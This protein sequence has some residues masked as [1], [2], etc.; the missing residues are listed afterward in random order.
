MLKLH[1]LKLI[2]AFHL[3]RLFLWEDK[4]AVKPKIYREKE[5]SI[6]NRSIS[7][8]SLKVL[9]R[10]QQKGFEAYLVGGGVRDLLLDHQPK[11]FD[12]ATNAHPNEIKSIFNNCRIIGRRFRLAHILFGRD[13][14]EVAT[15]RADKEEESRHF[16]KSDTGFLMRDNIYGEIDDD[17]V[18]RDFT[19]NALYYNPE[20]GEIIDYCGGF[21]DLKRREI[22]LIGDPDQRFEEDPVRLL[23]AVR[24]EA[25]LG[26]TID[27][28]L[29][30]KLKEFAPLLMHVSPSRM[31]DEVIKLF[32][33][34]HGEA[35]F[36]SLV[37]YDLFKYL[38]PGTA[39]A[40][41]EGFPENHLLE[42]ALRNS[43]ARHKIGR[44][45]SPYFLYA[46]LMW[47][48]FKVR[49]DS[50]KAEGLQ[51]FP[52]VEKAAEDLFREQR[53]ITVFPR[54]VKD[55]IV[56]LWTF[57]SRLTANNVRRIGR[58]LSHE[59]FKPAYDFILLRAESGESESIIERANFWKER[60][61]K[62]EQ[63]QKREER[64]EPK[65]IT[66]EQTRRRRPRNRNQSKEN[67]G[68]DE[69]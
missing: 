69:S 44:N 9:K 57:Q 67:H 66:R 45:S 64:D 14:I 36:Q 39:E 24:F 52:A 5:H 26:F 1:A 51:E 18:R 22:R 4:N 6:S 41:K 27:P 31:Y 28:K 3:E 33:T 61:E 8:N 54:Y 58:I 38:F 25:K 13:I 15:F 32:L 11:D 59:R 47:A 29:V 12:I 23:R 55:L 46:S 50:Y 16:Q 34:G 56:E 63:K 20:S 60:W 43:D 40:F 68:N 48:D 37:K 62:F 21:E 2:K 10:L 49:Y 65:R 30:P 19:I 17:A 53:D 35:S 42:V 7:K